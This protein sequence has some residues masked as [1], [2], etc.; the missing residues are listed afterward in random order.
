MAMP[1][2]PMLGSSRGPTAEGRIPNNV[3]WILRLVVR[4]GTGVGSLRDIDVRTALSLPDPDDESKSDGPSLRDKLKQRLAEAEAQGV[5]QD[6]PLPRNV[7]TL[8][9]LCRL[10]GIDCAIVALVATMEIDPGLRECFLAPHAMP[11]RELHRLVSV[12]LD[13]PKS[14]V[15]HALRPQGALRATRLLQLGPATRHEPPVALVD[16][17]AD[18][19][20]REHRGIDGL[21]AFF[22]RRA[23][24]T[25]LSLEDF[26]HMREGVELVAGV[27]R[28][29]LRTR[30]H[31]VNLLFYGDPGTGKTELARALA[32]SMNAR[33]YQVND[34]D[35]DG[36]SIEGSCRLG[37]CALAQRMLSRARR[38]LL[39]FDEAE[40][41]FP[42]EA[43]AM[44]GMRQR[45]TEQKS[46]THRLLE[47][48]PVPTIWIAN[49]ADQIDTATLRRFL[50]AIEL[51]TPPRPVRARMI[52][53]RLAR[54][55]VDS[56]WVERVAADDRFTPAD[57]D[58]VARVA[59]LLGR[60]SPEQLELALTQVVDASLTLAGPA[61]AT[62][63]ASGPTPYSL[64]FIN[65]SVDLE[66]FADA[67]TGSARGTI[68]LYGPPGTGKTAYVQHVAERLGK[69]LH[70]V[71]GSDL[72]GM[73]VGQTEQNLA[74]AFRKAASEKAILFLDE[75]DGLLQERGRATRS[76]E[77]TQVNELLV[78]MES[79]AGLLFCAT[80][81][82][83]GL[84]AA[85]LRRFGLKIRFDP[86]RPDQRL[87]LFA[88]VA[89]PIDDGI[90]E[91][92]ERMDELTAGDF[93][94]ALRRLAL[95]A[96]N[97]DAGALVRALA[98]EWTLKRRTQRPVQGFHLP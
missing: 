30:A 22:V 46:W 66:K 59:R 8:G 84:D 2:Q 58:K 14:E 57:A 11:P 93:A 4:G 15:T 81:L 1:F 55:R 85:S 28:G 79:F 82:V 50:I 13:V 17:F 89:G 3:L 80:N 21:V 72:L 71:R 51:R 60:R 40:D 62:A 65:A 44:F 52:H 92:L 74:R 54:T 86:L 6:G 43:F 10:T 12:A 18:V 7:A 90:R 64:R 41:V 87:E 83:E 76:W 5:A 69:P 32:A 88:A 20:A 97:V 77:V 53:R 19:L 47:E 16:G 56:R 31:G 49:R 94:T 26:A 68:C 38:P 70:S 91:R 27:L 95:L 35:S 73:Y 48:T 75:V 39:V 42:H 9:R 45:S 96:M 37:A 24:R 23:P 36:D 63:P 34:A 33:I 61:R 29:A 78:Q 25:E 98:E 67:L